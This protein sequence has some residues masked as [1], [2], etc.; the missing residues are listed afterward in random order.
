MNHE[1]CHVCG[2]EFTLM[3]YMNRHQE[4]KSNCPNWGMLHKV[5]LCDCSI[6]YHEDC[7]P[8]C[9]P[10]QKQLMAMDESNERAAQ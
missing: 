3:E 8:E 7:C 4:H 6:L 5:T 10:I 9:E 2:L 1:T